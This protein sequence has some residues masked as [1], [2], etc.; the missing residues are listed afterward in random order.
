ML[1]KDLDMLILQSARQLRANP[2]ERGKVW[3][4]VAKAAVVP[5]DG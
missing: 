4:R 5:G 2:F 1:I 3:S